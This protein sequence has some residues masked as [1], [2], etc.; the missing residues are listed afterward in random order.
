MKHFFQLEKGLIIIGGDS[1]YFN[2]IF[3]K[4]SQLREAQ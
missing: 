3:Y 4:N 2:F 1:H